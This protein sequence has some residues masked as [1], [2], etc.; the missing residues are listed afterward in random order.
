MS[1]AVAA[2]EATD[3]WRFAVLAESVIDRR[4]SIWLVEPVANALWQ[5]FGNE[6]LDRLRRKAK[7]KTEERNGTL[8]G[9]KAPDSELHAVL[10]AR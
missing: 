10:D 9:L 7:K 8:F 5:R 1:A 2:K 6:L 3:W 4:Y